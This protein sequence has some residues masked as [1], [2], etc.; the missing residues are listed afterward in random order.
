TTEVRR[1]ERPMSFYVHDERQLRG[2]AAA[3]AVPM[4]EVL[5]SDT[6]VGAVV[7]KQGDAVRIVGQTRGVSIA[8]AGE[9][10][11]QGRVGDRIAVKNLASGQL[12]QAVVTG[13]GA[14][15]VSF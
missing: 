3:R 5:T 12:L 14:V 1:L 4:R 11:A 10:R 7:V 8:A 6:I 9:A 13:D 15:R 2:V